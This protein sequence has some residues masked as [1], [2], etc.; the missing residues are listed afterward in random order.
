[1]EQVH[2]INVNDL[3]LPE[4]I[5]DS[6]SCNYEVCNDSYKRYYPI[7][8]EMED[9]NIINDSLINYGLELEGKD[10]SFYILLHFSW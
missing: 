6:L 7:A 4:D 3:N 9:K 8:N 2:V 5:Y 1:M 10:T